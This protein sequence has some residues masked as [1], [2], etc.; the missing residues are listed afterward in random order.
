[1]YT[2][3]NNILVLIHFL[4]FL[5]TIVLLKEYSRANAHKYRHEYKISCMNNP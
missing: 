5:S 2:A 4:N 1:M 3:N